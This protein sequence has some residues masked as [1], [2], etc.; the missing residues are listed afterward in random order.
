MRGMVEVTQ[1][2]GSEE[3]L[4]DPASNVVENRLVET[5]VANCFLVG[6]HICFTSMELLAVRFACPQQVVRR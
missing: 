2:R 4:E 5:Y 6:G 1:V 3:T